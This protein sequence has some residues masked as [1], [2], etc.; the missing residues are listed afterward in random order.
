M[1]RGAQRLRSNEDAMN[2]LMT[3]H[4]RLD[5]NAGAPGVTVKLATALR[6]RGHNVEL[7]SY[8]DM[9]A[10]PSIA[11]NVLFPWFVLARVARRPDY[12]V[13]DL[14][15]GDGWVIN[16]LRRAFGWRARQ[17]SATRSHGME[18]MVHEA[19]VDAR[20]HGHLTTNWKYPIYWGGLRIWECTKSFKWADLALV[21]NDTERSY[22]V[23][24]LNMPARRVAVVDNGIDEHFAVAAQ[25]TLEREDD[26]TVRPHRIAFMGRANYWKGM[27]TMVAA[28]S[29]LLARHPQATIKVLGAGEPEEVTR[30][31][32]DAAVQAQV[33]V[34]PRYDNA[35]LKEVLSDC[36]LLAYPSRFDG[37]PLSPLEAMACGLVPV[38]TDIG[39]LRTYIRD[40]ENGVLVQP[41]N[42]QALSAALESL[43][44]DPARW[45]ALRRCALETATHYSWKELAHR[46]EALYAAKFQHNPGIAAA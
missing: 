27:D 24:E 26:D 37:F 14:S 30:A 31:R 43:I 28:A 15:A 2:I 33:I 34:V 12:D 3:I 18:P 22:A 45:R 7:M 38:A 25:S 46:F 21:L 10:L 16:L 11:I 41:G 36:Q 1:P 8:D 19:L 42:P 39:A 17:L 9:P 20:R 35:R 32:F 23:R 13:L 40:G 4:H 44:A 6:A 29:T 5:T